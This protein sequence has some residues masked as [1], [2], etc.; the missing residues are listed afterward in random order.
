MENLGQRL[1][2]RIP[3][4]DKDQVNTPN[5]NSEFVITKGNENGNFKIERDPITNEGLLYLTKVSSSPTHIV[6]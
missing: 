2:L 3:V 6:H 4:E 5:W 1:L